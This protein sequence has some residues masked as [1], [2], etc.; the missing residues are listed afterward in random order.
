[1][2]NNLFYMYPVFF[3][4]RGM[5][6]FHHLTIKTSFIFVSVS[7]SREFRMY[8]PDHQFVKLAQTDRT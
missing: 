1:M 3:Y 7:Q 8:S 6:G 5:E 2:V 4:A